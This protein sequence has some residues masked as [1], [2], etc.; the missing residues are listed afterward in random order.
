MDRL[1]LKKLRTGQQKYAEFDSGTD[2]S[3]DEE[4]KISYNIQEIV[5]L[6]NKDPQPG[7]ITFIAKLVRVPGVEFNYV[8][9]NV[10]PKT[11]KQIL[12]VQQIKSFGGFAIYEINTNS[13]H[14][15]IVIHLKSKDRNLASSKVLPFTPRAIHIS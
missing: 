5:D 2:H 7:K 4:L 12:G 3:S 14:K 11:H 10:R 9:E 8:V 13:S 1:I 15:Q 6:A